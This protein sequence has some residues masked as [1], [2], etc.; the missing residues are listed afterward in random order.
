MQ[1]I[2]VTVLRFF[3]LFICIKNYSPDINLFQLGSE[4][5]PDCSVLKICCDSP[6]LFAVWAF[7]FAE[8]ASLL[9]QNLIANLVI[10]INLHAVLVCCVKIGLVL[11]VISNF[12][13]V[14]YKQDVKKHIVSKY[15]CTWRGFK[16]F[17]I[18]RVN[19]PCCVVK[20]DINVIE[21]Y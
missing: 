4:L 6:W 16:N 15:F 17:V 13:P 10:I 3:I 2:E 21:G 9:H 5:S 20:E 18:G 1:G 8:D 11:P 12:V 7:C 19:G 14:S